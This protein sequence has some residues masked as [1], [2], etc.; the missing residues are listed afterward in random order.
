MGN[1]M[2]DTRQT[3][4]D[5]PIQASGGTMFAARAR[6]AELL[7]RIAGEG[8][9]ADAI[10][11]L[12]TLLR[13]RDYSVADL[14]EDSRA[15]IAR[16]AEGVRP[17]LEQALSLCL[18]ATAAVH[19]AAIETMLHG[20]C[21]LDETGCV[22]YANGALQG[23]IPDCQGQKLNL[24]LDVDGAW[25]RK[26]ILPG[27]DPKA[28]RLE[29]QSGNGRRP[30][31]VELGP[32]AV[33]ARGGFAVVTDLTVEQEGQRRI[34]DMAEFAILRLDAED[35]IT[36]ANE[37]ACRIL[38]AAP[39]NVL[40]LRPADFIHDAGQRQRVADE[41]KRR[42][43][44]ISAE[45]EVEIQPPDADNP[46][47]I[48]VRSMPEMDSDGNLSGIFVTLV[49]I[50]A[51][52]AA[53]KIQR[54]LAT[55]ED[56][57]A[58]FESAVEHLRAALPFSRASLSVYAPGGRYCRLIRSAPD[59]EANQRWVLLPETIREFAEA[60]TTIGTDIEEFLREHQ[61][62]SDNPGV[63]ELIGKGMKSWAS[64]AVR[65]CDWQAVFT[66]MDKE[67]G[68]YTEESLEKLARTGIHHAMH[69][70]LKL[71]DE[72][73]KAFQLSLIQKM[74]QAQGDRDLADIVVQ[75]L[76]E[77]Y[78]W[79]NVSIFK[80]NA[81]QGQL[82]LLTQASNGRDGYALPEGYRQPLD[83]GYLGKA[84]SER[85][86][87]VVGDAEEERTALIFAR[88]SALTRSEMCVPIQVQDMIP[89]I[90]NI[91]DR[92][93][94]AF[95][96]PDRES[97]ERLMRELEPSLERAL[98]A[99]LLDQVLEDAPDGVVITDFESRILRSNR[100]AAAMLGETGLGRNLA[101]FFKPGS[102]GEEVAK[103]ARSERTVP[104]PATIIGSAG[105]T[106]EVLMRS[107]VPRD[108]YQRRIVVLQDLQKMDWQAETRRLAA[109]T[110][111]ARV[112]LSMIS[113]FVRHIAT[114][115]EKSDPAVASLAEHAIKQLSRVE[116]TY[117]RLI[118]SDSRV[119]R[120]SK[121]DLAALLAE[122]IG[123]LPPLQRGLVRIKPTPG[124]LPLLRCDRARVAT[125][126]ESMLA[127]LLRV[128]TADNPI[129]ARLRAADCCLELR[130]FKPRLVVGDAAL[131]EESGVGSATDEARARAALDEPRLYQLAALHGGRF[132]RHRGA[133][134]ETLRLVLAAK[135]ACSQ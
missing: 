97:V 114:L 129:S 95:Q 16:G 118:E 35:H 53:E 19:E 104:I 6:A 54:E 82:E 77:F 21:E 22:T 81:L 60:E 10:E 24:Y 13:S 87:Q 135:G 131:P 88:G 113:T 70:V 52:I 132:S 15:A 18:N 83:A 1:D 37:A 65:G 38:H 7:E 121:V 101:D 34:D 59:M 126:L 62:L 119:R 112:P 68:R 17:V 69:R 56:P 55:A 48:R 107:R 40:G 50:D 66:I 98:S 105:G 36:Y 44:G 23:M 120:R 124:R 51:E 47:H 86:I 43:E 3:L 78:D 116:L 93:P 32:L 127:Y 75:A 57:D 25:L 61:S 42:H 133:H 74:T 45:Y 71:R 109:V 73:E 84:L 91:E 89:W 79:H 117:D 49:P 26:Q 9:E 2:Q 100:V 11:A 27:A 5:P 30:V 99:A 64:I 102:K 29:I 103:R 92:R 90:L 80:V 8:V 123:A 41:T 134:G 130:L 85:K 108:E 14:V 115:A 12:L 28:H 111:E 67:K 46:M 106:A 31:L 4:S 33:A 72:R 63:Q 110:A 20:F 58:L 96:E 125:A 94:C 128:G 76:A 39:E 122:T